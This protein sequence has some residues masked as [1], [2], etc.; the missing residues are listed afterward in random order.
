MKSFLLNTE[1]RLMK[2]CCPT[3]VT[4]L[5][6]LLFI[7]PAPSTAQD[8]AVGTVAID[9]ETLKAAIIQVLRED[10]KL[11]YDALNTYQ[12]QMA[13][14]SQQQL[15]NSFKNPV[16]IPVRP[17]N[18]AKG[19]EKAP[20]TI[21]SFMD[22]QCPYCT[23]AIATLNS[24][25]DKYPGKLRLVYKN[26]PLENHAAALDAAKAALAAHRQGKFWEFRDLLYADMSQLNE[27]G[28]VRLAKNLGMNLDA[29]NADRRSE[30]IARVIAADQEEAMKN[31]IRSVPFF[32]V[33]G[34]MVKGAKD[35]GYFSSV[36][37]R[38]LGPPAAGAQGAPPAQGATKQ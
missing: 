26:N 3:L 31:N 6:G 10:P 29:F 27:E 7:I 22:F 11:V 28:Y 14:N 9:K 21:I 17:E 36:I 25:M 35:I 5:A 16:S 37:D 33:N 2:T 15:E 12:Q 32:V 8:V 34:V 30:A 24:L 19:P 18:P 4:V 1:K 13:G 23:R 38:L 20:I